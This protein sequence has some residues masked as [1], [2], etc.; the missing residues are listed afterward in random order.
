MP[1]RRDLGVRLTSAG[2]LALAPVA[3]VIASSIDGLGEVWEFLVV[4][5]RCLAYGPTWNS[6]WVCKQMPRQIMSDKLLEGAID[7]I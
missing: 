4:E 5:S 1:T 3:A 7:S 6:I 2:V